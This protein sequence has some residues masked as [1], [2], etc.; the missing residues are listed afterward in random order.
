[1]G[2]GHHHDRQVD[3]PVDVAHGGHRADAGDLVGR[4]V[5]RV[6]GSGETMV[7]HVAQHGVTDPARIA[8]STDDRHGLG[9]QQPAHRLGLRALRPGGDRRLRPGRRPQ[10][11]VD[12]DH[13]VPEAAVRREPR[14]AEH[15]D[16][17][18][19]RGQHRR[20]ERGDAGL[21]GRLG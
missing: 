11:E 2:G 16:H 8:S 1:V 4:R 15:R 7:Q 10:V 17:A 20:R 18:S 13:A 9:F 14:V 12:L 3:G 19:V 6:H 21:A 5:D